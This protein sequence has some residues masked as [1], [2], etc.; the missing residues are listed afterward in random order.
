MASSST[1][2]IIWT[3]L[4]GTAGSEVGWSVA[5]GSDGAVYVVG[6]TIG[7][8]DG[9]V[10]AGTD[11]FIT[12]FDAGGTK[13]WTKLLGSVSTDVASTV[14]IGADGSILV[15]GYT[16]GSFDNQ[17]SSGSYDGFI[18]K[19]LSDGTNVWTRF[20]GSPSLDFIHA[21]AVGSDSSIYVAGETRGSLSGEQYSGG[22]G[23]GF[24]SKFDS[25]GV[26]LWTRL[27]GTSAQ[28]RAQALAIGVDGSI[29]IAGSSNGNLLGEINSGLSDGFVTKLNSNGTQ[30]WT[31]LLGSSPGFSQYEVAYSIAVSQDNSIYVAGSAG[32]VIDNQISNGLSDAFLAKYDQSGTRQWTRFLG[33]P[34]ETY[35]VTVTT[36]GSILIAGLTGGNLDTEQ[37]GG[38]GDA[39]LVKYNP[40]GTRGWA[41]LVGTSSADTGRGVSA[42]AS[43]SVVIAGETNG[44]LNSQVGAGGTDAFVTQFQ[45]DVSPPTISVASTRLTLLADQTA[46]ITFTLSEPSTDFAVTDLVVSGGTI[47]G[48]TGTGTSYT[49]TFTPNANSTTDGV[50]SVASGKFSDAAGNLNADGADANNTV[51]I[52]VNT[53]QQSNPICFARGTLIH[54][55]G[56]AIPVESLTTGSTVQNKSG[57]IAECRWIGYQRRTPEFAQFQDYLP[58]KIS[59]GALD[60]NLPLRDLYLSPDHAVLVDGH[61]IHAKALVNGKTI[62]QMT[63]WAGDIEYYHIETESHEIIY[64]EGVPCETFIDNVSREQFDNYAEYQALYPNT[65]MMKELPLPRV[66]FKRQLPLAIRQRLESRISELDSQKKG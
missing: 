55:T 34:G 54:T 23:D 58:V 21:I 44:N 59:A 40:D 20:L 49:A 4:L 17:T 62:V 33:P 30:V 46:S 53:T 6:S 8:L 10:N 27:L 5:Q 29:Y 36:D 37:N 57:G 14:T 3:K 7:A 15:A 45:L 43:G 19:L 16:L 18:T 56:E 9:I 26:L 32:G 31:R 24:V 48:F 39:F 61:L 28:D 2:S 65:R 52:T 35:A 63:Q 64:A 47:S 12:K 1:P 50:I 25:S 66:K 42:L 11:A 13:A 60:D 22:D 51:T 41:R 38:A